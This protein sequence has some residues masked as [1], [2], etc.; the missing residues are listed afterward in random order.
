MMWQD[1]PLAKCMALQ[2]GAV[3]GLGGGGSDSAHLHPHPSEFY[4]Q[5][6]SW[7]GRGT[8][9]GSQVSGDIGDIWKDWLARAG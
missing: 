2:L 3:G 7:P 9:G 8:G 4:V 6:H 1:A 5:P